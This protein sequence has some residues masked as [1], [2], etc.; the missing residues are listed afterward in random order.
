[1]KGN[2]ITHGVRDCEAKTNE[3]LVSVSAPANEISLLLDNNILLENNINYKNKEKI[4]EYQDL[5]QIFYCVGISLYN[6][7]TV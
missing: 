7:A 1:M 4:G 6:Y 2:S 3:V 5:K